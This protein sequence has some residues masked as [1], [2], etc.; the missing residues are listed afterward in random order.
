M[1]RITLRMSLLTVVLTLLCLLAWAM[2]AAAITHGTYD[3]GHPYVCLVQ[4][5][6]D[7]RVTGV[8][9]SDTVVLTAGHG[10]YGFDADKAQVWFSPQVDLSVPG[11]VP[12]ELATYPGYASGQG[13]VGIVILAAPHRLTEYAQL[14]G[15]GVVDGLPM[16]QPVDLVG[17]GGNYQQRGG[18]L[19]PLE[20]WQWLNERQYAP[21]QLI[22]SKC[23]MSGQYLQLTSNPAAGK[24]GIAFG[25]S[26]GPVLKA[27]TNV[28]LGVNTFV[29]SANCTGV[30]YAQRLDLPY[31]LEWIGGFLQ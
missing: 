18:G 22:Q 6:P 25:D 15:V 11:A 9:L 3:A 21:A 12:A 16:M 7:W 13:D 27:G 24:G 31:I 23:K 26:G 8:Q 20:S 5:A 17:Y 19:T 28:V 30:A 4:L 29:T 10:T 2:P 1:K 14:P